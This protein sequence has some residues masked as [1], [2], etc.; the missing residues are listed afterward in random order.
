MDYIKEI[1]YRMH[2]VS[3][4]ALNVRRALLYGKLE[5]GL[6]EMSSLRRNLKDA[7]EMLQRYQEEAQKPTPLSTSAEEE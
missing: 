4:S 5:R 6:Q 7:E 1:L 2:Q 3:Q